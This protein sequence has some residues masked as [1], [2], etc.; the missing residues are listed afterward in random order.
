M[1]KFD[2]IIDYY[3][4]EAKKNFKPT[5][6]E[7]VSQARQ[8]A[9]ENVGSPKFVPGQFKANE[10]EELMTSKFSKDIAEINKDSQSAQDMKQFFNSWRNG[11]YSPTFEKKFISQS[12]SL[13]NLAREAGENVPHLTLYAVTVR[14]RTP[15]LRLLCT[16]IGKKL[17]WLRAFLGYD[18]Y[19]TALTHYR[20]RNS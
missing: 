4:L 17:I 16:K 13:K 20:R 14:E 9:E 3:L 19:D 6:A 10:V 5:F 2:S 15:A 12:I 7:I 8:E 11:E 1:S 18:S